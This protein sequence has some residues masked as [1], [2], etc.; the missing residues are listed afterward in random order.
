LANENALLKQRVS[1]RTPGL[2]FSGA[3]LK[4]LRFQIAE[5]EQR[6]LKLESAKG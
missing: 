6:L 3:A 2:R 1:P 5:M 4:R